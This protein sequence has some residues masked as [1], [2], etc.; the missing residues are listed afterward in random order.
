M[1]NYT[2]FC[3]RMLTFL[4]HTFCFGSY[5]CYH[6]KILN[7]LFVDSVTLPF[8]LL[9]LLILLFIIVFIFKN[10]RLINFQIFI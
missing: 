8:L 5:V 10:L 2:V 9:L 7:R 1:F 3:N 4:N 6:G